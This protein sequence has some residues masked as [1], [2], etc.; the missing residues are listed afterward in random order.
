M[1]KKEFEDRVGLQV[2]NEEYAQIEK[3]YMD[4]NGDKDVFCQE[5]LNKLTGAEYKAMSE[6]VIEIK[7]PPL[8]KG[9]LTNKRYM[10]AV[11]NHVKR[12]PEFKRAEPIIDYMSA[13]EFE[14]R[15][16]TKY[17]FDF[18]AVVN[19]GCSEGIYVDC[20]LLGEFDN[21][22]KR[23]FPMGTI[24]TLECSQ[25]A[26]MIMGELA[27]LLTWAAKECIQQQISNGYFEQ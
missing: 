9:T 25:N 19:F 20:W 21:S 22:D 24:K 16:I 12:M 27:G 15:E 2:T 6:R 14:L 11:I 4:S 26:M 13:E 3:A 8:T 5:W 10:E 17:E 7:P 1:M 23:Q 18:R